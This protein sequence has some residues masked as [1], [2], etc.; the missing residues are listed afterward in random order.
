MGMTVAI[1]DL[2]CDAMKGGYEA[3]ELWNESLTSERLYCS[4]WVLHPIL[5]MPLLDCLVLGIALAKGGGNTAKDLRDIDGKLSKERSAAAL[6]VDNWILSLS[7][8]ICIAK[9][10]QLLVAS[11]LGGGNNTTTTNISANT[12]STTISNMNSNASQ[13]H[14][15]IKGVGDEDEKGGDKYSERVPVSPGGS[16]ANRDMNVGDY[17]RDSLN[18][19]QPYRKYD[20]RTEFGSKEFDIDLWVDPSPI[21]EPLEY[22]DALIKSLSQLVTEKIVRDMN[23]NALPWSPEKPDLELI[24]LQ[25]KSFLIVVVHSLYRLRPGLLPERV[26]DNNKTTLVELMTILGFCGDSTGH[27]SDIN[28]SDE[29]EMYSSSSSSQNQVMK[30]AQDAKYSTRYHNNYLS[31]SM[32]LAITKKWINAI[33]SRDYNS[34]TNLRAS[35]REVRKQGLSHYPAMKRPMLISLP[36]SYTQL[37]GQITAL[38]TYDYPAICLVCGSVLDAGMIWMLLLLEYLLPYPHKH[39]VP[40]HSTLTYLFRIIRWK[41]RMYCPCRTMLWRW[42]IAVLVTS[43]LYSYYKILY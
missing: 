32:A 15:D 35:W 8:W 10:V 33:R 5:K 30:P 29:K 34:I 37:H 6:E 11:L 38:C 3:F 36:P 31:L 23:L 18:N 13:L 43:L 22:A 17:V 24:K 40:N 2:L 25:W 9:L 39:N 20:S 16:G 21:F 42:R 1:H 4:H 27:V 19:D 7:R 12:T 26:C 14:D 41:R 28:I